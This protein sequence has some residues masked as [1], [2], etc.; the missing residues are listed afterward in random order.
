[1]NKFDIICWCLWIC[2][3]WCSYCWAAKFGLN[4]CS[5][6][7]I[8]PIGIDSILMPDEAIAPFNVE[9]KFSILAH[10]FIQNT[11]KKILINKLIDLSSRLAPPTMILKG[12]PLSQNRI[13]WAFDCFFF[14]TQV[15]DKN[16]KYS[17]KVKSIEM[18]YRWSSWTSW[19]A[20]Y[21][22]GS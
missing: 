5:F 19:M 21:F 3:C 14:F 12:F 22:I 15:K 6:I 2:C 16:F 18:W 4:G 11:K 7:S 1:M 13:R 8:G 9:L 10:I 17:H 20:S